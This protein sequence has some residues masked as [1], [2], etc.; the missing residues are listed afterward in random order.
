M[1]KGERDISRDFFKHY[2]KPYRE[3]MTGLEILTA[4][5]KAI[6]TINHIHTHK[7][8]YGLLMMNS[9]LPQL[10]QTISWI[11]YQLRKKKF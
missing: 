3:H 10:G 7:F 9:H 5:I 6:D 4:H 8:S 11:S 2:M 1:K